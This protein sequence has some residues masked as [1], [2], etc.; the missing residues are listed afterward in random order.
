[1]SDVVW[2]P[3]LRLQVHASRAQPNPAFLVERLGRRGLAYPLEAG[4]CFALAAKSWREDYPSHRTKTLMRTGLAT[5]APHWH[6]L[7]VAALAR[8]E[9]PDVEAPLD[10]ELEAASITCHLS[11]LWS[12][13]GYWVTR[14]GVAFA[15]RALAR[16]AELTTYGKDHLYLDERGDW[17]VEARSRSTSQ[18][19]GLTDEWP[20]LRALI[21]EAP[22]AEYAAARDAAAAIIERSASG[23]PWERGM[24]LWLPF[25]F[26]DEPAFAEVGRA[27]ALEI[28][29]I[30]STTKN[31]SDPATIAIARYLSVASI[32]TGLAVLAHRKAVIKFSDVL[33]IIAHRGLATAMPLIEASLAKAV[34]ETDRKTWCK[35]YFALRVPEIVSLAATRFPESKGVAAAIAKYDKPPK[36]KKS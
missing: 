3:E 7:V 19:E 21:A 2:T 1:M 35:A 29:E 4:A 16:C 27:T 9:H 33:T 28:S 30:V 34:T 13:S 15:V 20:I 23:K 24:L 6:A 14:G 5:N 25:A 11:R 36:A 12:S 10:V 17:I 22:D 18:P 31:I 26:P 8:C 32:E